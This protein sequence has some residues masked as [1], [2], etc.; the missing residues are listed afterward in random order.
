MLLRLWCQ[1]RTLTLYRTICIRVAAR[2]ACDLPYV[3]HQLAGR[4]RREQLLELVRILKLRLHVF[5]DLRD[6]FPLALGV[7]AQRARILGCLCVSFEFLA[8]RFAFASAEDSLLEHVH[9][10]LLN[11]NAWDFL[12]AQNFLCAERA[13]WRA[14]R[15]RGVD[16]QGPHFVS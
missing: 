1:F 3:R 7:A 9:E 8:V 12:H 16:R 2:F 5:L 13:V 4:L 10:V 11:W 14:L 6:G 15:V